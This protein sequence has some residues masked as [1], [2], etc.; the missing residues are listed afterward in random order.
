[1]TDRGTSIALGYVLTIAIITVLVGGLIISGSSFLTDQRENVINEELSVIGNQ[2]AGNVEQADRMVNA[3]AGD[4]VQVRIAEQFQRE[5]GGTGYRVDL[6][7]ESSAEDDAPKIELSSSNPDITR[8]VNVT[9]ETPIADSSTTGGTVSIY[10]DPDAGSD[11]ALVIS[12][13]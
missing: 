1:M 11:G 9:T 13:E 5:V 3:S 2:L 12:D 8:T 10:Y 7:N 6:V 4:D